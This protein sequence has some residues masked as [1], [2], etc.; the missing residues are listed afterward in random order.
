[1][2]AWAVCYVAFMNAPSNPSPT[3]F[4]TRDRRECREFKLVLDSAGIPSRVDTGGGQFVVVVDPPYADRAA[5]ELH[6]YRSENASR[7]VTVASVRQ[8][9]GGAKTGVLVYFALIIF[10]AV[11]SLK[12]GLGVDLS[13]AGAMQAA[14]FTAGDWWRAFT[15]LTLH[16][17][18]GHVISNLLF[19]SLFGYFAG[20]ALGGGVAWLAI[21][22]AGALGN[23]INALIQSPHHTS[24]GAS[25]A[26]FAALGIIVANALRPRISK[27]ESLMR[28]W[29]P[30]IAGMMIFSLIGVGGER[31]D[32]MA[33]VTGFLSGLLIGW[34]VQTV[35]ARHFLSAR[36]QL[37][38][39][40]IAVAAILAAWTTALLN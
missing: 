13:T 11:I 10:I 39:G 40:A 15:A 24:I 35:A 22:L 27:S 5:D 4:E 33:H 23:A 34:A 21:V 8:D 38:C 19:G 6:A 20:R 14:H 25:T 29:T 1:M 28:R 32:V 17:D 18:I 12:Q 16:L 36:L 2:A 31:T 7:S 37:G 26:V 9:G 3:V 30:L